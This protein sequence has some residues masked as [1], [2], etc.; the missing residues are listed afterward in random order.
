METTRGPSVPSGSGPERKNSGGDG[1]EVPDD[2]GGAVL[3]VQEALGVEVLGGLE[4]PR[5]L[6]GRE[7]DADAHAE[8]GHAPGQLAG[9]VVAEVGPDRIARQV[10]DDRAWGSGDRP[11]A[12]T[13]RAN[14]R[15]GGSAVSYP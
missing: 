1:G 13:A 5:D 2:G 7:H 12:R 3:L 15:S 11:A 14:A 10:A 8:P 4:D 6:P 9:A